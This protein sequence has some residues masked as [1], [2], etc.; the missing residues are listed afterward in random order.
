[1]TTS[2]EIIVTDSNY[3]EPFINQHYPSNSFFNMTVDC[4][5]AAMAYVA[6]KYKPEPGKAYKQGLYGHTLHLEPE[7]I[8]QIKNE[9]P[10]MVKANG[11]LYADYAKVNASVDKLTEHAG[12]EELMRNG[13]KEEIL[14]FEF[15]G[16][17]WRCKLDIIG[18][19]YIAD[20]KFLASLKPNERTGNS[21]PLIFWNYIQQ[22]ALYG[23][24]YKCN[25][26]VWPKI[27]M[28][29]VSKELKPVL[30]W[31]LID[32]DDPFDMEQLN[33]AL[34]VVFAKLPRMKEVWAGN[35]EPVA[36]G[37][38]DHCK[39][40]MDLSDTAQ[41]IKLKQIYTKEELKELI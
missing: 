32:P 28:N 10:E 17:T 33:K 39:G 35:V 41:P 13:R 8:Q 11:D 6:G 21:H 4:E 1:M 40:S 2:G 24:A 19:G 9:F 29:C 15:G 5:D 36:C 16:I 26:G 23:W 31:I 22:M 38:C 37:C 3:Y 12:I 27:Y 7:K 25:F 30:Q 34:D 14:M 20:D 18:D